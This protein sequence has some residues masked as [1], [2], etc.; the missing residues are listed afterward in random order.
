MR[1]DP[2][3]RGLGPYQAGPGSASFRLRS[4]A[5]NLIVTVVRLR[6]YCSLRS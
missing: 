4:A 1:A 2:E 5:C 6:H 3:Q